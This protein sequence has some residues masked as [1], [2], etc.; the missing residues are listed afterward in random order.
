MATFLGLQTLTL[1]EY[2]IRM[3]LTFLSADYQ[4]RGNFSESLYD[5][6]EMCREIVALFHEYHNDWFQVIQNHDD[7]RGFIPSRYT[8]EFA[9]S[10]FGYSATF[11][12]SN[13]DF[14]AFWEL[15]ETEWPIQGMMAIDPLFDEEIVRRPL[16]VFRKRKRE[17]HECRMF[18]M[19]KWSPDLWTFR[20][21][22]G[23]ND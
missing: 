16:S 19:K 9:Q 6:D 13:N 17:E 12:L 7:L 5:G 4:M 15:D 23:L 2:H 22:I 8:I 18:L 3:F 1:K 14:D 11:G 20:N 21:F 10:T